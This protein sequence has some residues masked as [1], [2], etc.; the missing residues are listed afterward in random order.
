MSVNS[1]KTVCWTMSAIVTLFMSYYVW[2][3]YQHQDQTSQT[4]DS[5]QVKAVLEENV[6]ASAEVADRV[7]YTDIQSAYVD[8]NWTGKPP[9]PPTEVNERPEVDTPPPVSF[10]PVS[11]LLSILMIQV[12]VTEPDDSRV[13]VRYKG[14][15]ITEPQGTLSVGDAL[16]QPH[17][18]IQVAAITVE[19]VEFS[20]EGTDRENE[21][22]TPTE[23][24]SDQNVIVRVGPGGER[25]PVT[26]SLIPQSSNRQSFNPTE[27]TL[28]GHNKYRIGTNDVQY[29]GEN[30]AKV[31]T[32]DVR[33]S[34]HRDE[35]GRRAGVKIDQV[36]AG[37]VAERHGAQEG[38]IIKSING[39]PV[40]SQQEAIKFVK[41]NSDRYTTWEVVVEN[42]GRERTVVYESPSE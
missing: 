30:Y 42:L 35:T 32:R 38:D 19:G 10:T 18:S 5:D 16:P 39:H 31:L 23:G 12:D 27:T 9:P 13:V 8:M 26:R 41:N 6:D 29:L 36:R 25:Y 37:S 7:N 28:V 17:Q 40:S 34:V 14:G 22:L 3:F 15:G 24:S 20:F 11:D 33:T 21:K 4:Y 2:D 1:I